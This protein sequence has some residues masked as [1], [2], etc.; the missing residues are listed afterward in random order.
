MRNQKGKVKESVLQ[1]W[2]SSVL[3]D[4]KDQ[5]KGRV[6]GN[7]QELYVLEKAAWHML[8]YPSE[9]HRPAERELVEPIAQLSFLPVLQC[10]AVAS[11]QPKAKGEG[12]M[13]LVHWG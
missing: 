10:P 11:T 4:L 1:Q 12:G 13:L 8:W 3:L 2:G 9:E 7:Q 5:S 6:T